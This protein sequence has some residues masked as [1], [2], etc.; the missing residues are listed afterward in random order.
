VSPHA[1]KDVRIVGT[2]VGG[3]AFDAPAPSRA[4]T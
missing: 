4:G 2:M 1:L 3:V